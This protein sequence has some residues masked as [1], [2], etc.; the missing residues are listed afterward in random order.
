M[1]AFSIF[2]G[3]AQFF[4]TISRIVQSIGD[5]FSQVGS[6]FSHIFGFAGDMLSFAMRGLA[7]YP[8]FLLSFALTLMSLSFIAI[9]IKLCP[10]IG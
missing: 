1:F 9:I 4:E 2:D 6:A 8:D 10:F 5:F 3:F 7:F